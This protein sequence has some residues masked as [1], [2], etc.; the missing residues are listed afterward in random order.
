MKIWIIHLSN[1]SVLLRTSPDGQCVQDMPQACPGHVPGVCSAFCR[2]GYYKLSAVLCDWQPLFCLSRSVCFLTLLNLLNACVLICLLCCLTSHCTG[3]QGPAC[4]LLLL[5]SF[6]LPLPP[7]RHFY[8]LRFMWWG[9]HGQTLTLEP[10]RELSCCGVNDLATKSSVVFLFLAT[11]RRERH[12]QHRER[13]R[14][15]WNVEKKPGL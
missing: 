1:W 3:C 8:L 7:I 6:P 13:E 4:L 15:S 5:L 12:L 2:A 14:L 10:P 11:D 9:R